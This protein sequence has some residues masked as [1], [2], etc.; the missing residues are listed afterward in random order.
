MSAASRLASAIHS[1]GHNPL[2]M[3]CKRI[4]SSSPT[5]MATPPSLDAISHPPDCASSGEIRCFSTSAAPSAERGRIS[6][7]VKSAAMAGA[8]CN[9]FQILSAISLYCPAVSPRYGYP[10][11]LRARR[12]RVLAASPAN[13]PSILN[14]LICLRPPICGFHHAGV[15]LPHSFRSLPRLQVLLSSPPPDSLWADRLPP[16]SNP[17]ARLR[18]AAF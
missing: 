6:V 16:G 2:P 7:I 3:T 8:V 15:R 14:V 13:P 10:L 5:M 1:L 18:R 17:H 12:T 4:W 9:A 11:R